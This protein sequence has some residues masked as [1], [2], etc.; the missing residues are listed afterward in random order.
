M[1]RPLVTPEGSFPDGSLV[2]PAT[3]K[4]LEAGPLPM[5]VIDWG[6]IGVGASSEAEDAGLGVLADENARWTRPG[7][8]DD[9]EP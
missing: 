8:W 7:P 5:A 4:D 9:D 2:P 3:Y 6:T 1:E